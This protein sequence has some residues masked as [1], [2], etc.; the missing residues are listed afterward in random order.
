VKLHYSLKEIEKIGPLTPEGKS[1][2]ARYVREAELLIE[3]LS[4]AHYLERLKS[5]QGAKVGE[6]EMR[7]G[8]DLVKWRKISTDDETLRNGYPSSSYP[9]GD[10]FWWRK[11][12][13]IPSGGFRVDSSSWGH[14][15]R[16]NVRRRGK[17]KKGKSCGE[18]ARR[19]PKGDFLRKSCR[20]VGE[21]KII[22]DCISERRGK[23]GRG[24]GE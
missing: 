3:K 9:K 24:E 4:Q 16:S 14:I 18:E 6:K 5:L 22:S 12:G 7:K 23:C 15:G 10:L 19:K 21:G 11:S 13:G 17:N 8:G 20:I 2:L 1:E